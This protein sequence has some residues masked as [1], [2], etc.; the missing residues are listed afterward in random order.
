M[1]KVYWL[2]L[3]KQ[4]IQQNKIYNERKMRSSEQNKSGSEQK[5]LIQERNKSGSARSKS[6]NGHR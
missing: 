1:F 3:I 2:D 6:G 4:I 5:M